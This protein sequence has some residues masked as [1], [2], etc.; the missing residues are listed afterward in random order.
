MT[1]PPPYQFKNINVGDLLIQQVINPLKMDEFVR[2]RGIIIN[3]Q[4]SVSTVEWIMDGSETNNLMTTTS[5]L[6]SS[7]RKMIMNG[8]ILHY[9]VQK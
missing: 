4:N 5:I 9:P 7:L 3:I 2:R 6:N 1:M 8:Y